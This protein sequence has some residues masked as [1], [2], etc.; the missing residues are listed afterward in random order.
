MVD[1]IVLSALV[2]LAGA[3][4]FRDNAG[5]RIG[6]VVLLLLVLIGR[7]LSIDF[8]LRS[9]SQARFLAGVWTEEFRDGAHAIV[10]YCQATRVYV[11]VIS[12]LIVLLSIR[13]FRRPKQK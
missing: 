13:G 11:I 7:D 8:Y 6:A 10:D 9:A 12:I 2:V 5:L 3:A 4:F 1:I